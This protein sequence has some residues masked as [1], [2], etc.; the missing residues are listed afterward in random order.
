MNINNFVR[1][2]KHCIDRSEI[3]NKTM[4]IG[5]DPPLSTFELFKLSAN[6]EGRRFRHFY[7]SP[8]IIKLFLKILGKEVIS[9]KILGNL[10]IDIAPELKKFFKKS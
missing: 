2:L 6:T 9:Q 7:V 5:D 10:E 4:L 3:R 1:F 8:L